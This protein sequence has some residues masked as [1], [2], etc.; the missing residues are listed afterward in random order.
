MNKLSL[1]LKISFCFG[2]KYSYDINTAAWHPRLLPSEN[3]SS[4]LHN[5]QMIR[6]DNGT[7]EAN[8][9]EEKL[10]VK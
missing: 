7:M 2:F 8:Q 3:H 6:Y 1:C 4:Q 5:I 9:S 10:L